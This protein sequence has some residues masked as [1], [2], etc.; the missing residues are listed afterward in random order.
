M[1]VD[2]EKSSFALTRRWSLHFH[3]PSLSRTCL[4]SHLRLCSF[5]L[6]DQT[7]FSCYWLKPL[8]LKKEKRNRNPKT[9]TWTVSWTIVNDCSAHSNLNSSSFKLLYP[10]Q[11]ICVCINTPAWSAV[12]KLD[13][14]CSR[15]CV[16][17]GQK[18]WSH[19]ILFTAPLQSVSIS[20]PNQRS[21]AS[22]K[23]PAERDDGQAEEGAEGRVQRLDLGGSP[24]FS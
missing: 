12:V 16:S 22:G 6:F 17:T 8:L 10:E 13:P 1:Q 19:D 18:G 24:G 3:S 23:S 9:E 2:L 5:T 11:T 4:S 21:P 14:F 7:Q 15:P 20:H